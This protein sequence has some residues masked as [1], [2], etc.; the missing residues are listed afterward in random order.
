MQNEI[1]GQISDQQVKGID[2]I[3][4]MLIIFQALSFGLI[5]GSKNQNF[6]NR[7]FDYLEIHT[8]FKFDPNRLKIVPWT[9]MDTRQPSFHPHGHSFI[10]SKNHP[11]RLLRDIM[12]GFHTDILTL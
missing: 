4:Q 6:K 9:L 10:Y 11:S 3:G 2:L 8:G 1:T 12:Q 5:K 7:Y